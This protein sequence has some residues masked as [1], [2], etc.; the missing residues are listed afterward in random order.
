MTRRVMAAMFAVVGGIAF[1][2]PALAA[3]QEKPSFS[4]A[5][6]NGDGKVSTEEAKEAGFD[7]YQIVAQDVNQ[8]GMLTEEDWK[9]MSYR[10]NFNLSGID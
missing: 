8:D 5:D 10:S 9:Y 6:A 3:D 2:A 1:S 7:K 4:E